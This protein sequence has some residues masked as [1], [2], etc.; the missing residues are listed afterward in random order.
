MFSLHK[1]SLRW[2]LTVLY[3]CL[4]GDCSKAGTSLFSQVTSNRTREKGIR[5][6]Q[7][8]FRLAIKHWSRLPR[9]AVES[10]SQEVFK[11]HIHGA[12][13]DRV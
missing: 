4:K 11:R 5:L 13:G 7:G 12:H 9:E 1:R 8:R 2:N 3:S 10:L 6:H